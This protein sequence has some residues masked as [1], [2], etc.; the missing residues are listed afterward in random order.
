MNAAQERPD[1]DAVLRGLK[2]FQRETVERIFERMYGPQPSRRFLLADEVGLGKTL[3]AKGLIAKTLDHLWD[4]V[5]RIDVIYICSNADIARQN[6][7][8]LHPEEGGFTLPSRIT[9]LPLSIGDLASRKM[10]FVSFTPGTSLEPRSAMGTAEERALLVRMLR[11]P[12]EMGNRR[13]PCKVFQATSRSIESFE[14]SVREVDDRPLSEE[15]TA[16][17]REAVAARA[18]LQEA[19]GELLER[20][21]RVREPSSLPDDVKAARRGLI[22]ELRHLLAQTCVAALE[23]DLILLDEFQRFRHLLSGES[24][25]ADLA[26]ELFDWEDEDTGAQA[27]VLLMSATPYKMF[28]VHGEAE[29]D[30]YED[31]V[32]TLRFL[33]GEERATRLGGLLT[34]FRRE[35][36]SFDP[37]DAEGL[38]D[39]HE[40]IQRE[41]RQ[42][43]VRTERLGAGN[44]ANGMLETV[45]EPA[46]PVTEADVAD[47]LKGQQVAR[48]VG[49]SDVM[50]YWKSAPYLLNMLGD[51]YKVIR[52][53][54]ASVDTASGRASMAEILPSARLLGSDRIRRWGEIDA[55]SPR[56]RGLV[57]SMVGGG[58]WR[59]LWMPPS[60]PY[61]QLGG[62]FAG[63]PDD[64]TKRLVFSS[65]TVVPRAIASIV[66]YA[67]ERE[68]WAAGGDRSLNTEQ[69]RKA[70]Q[71]R[72]G[73]T[74]DERGRPTGMPLL[75][76]LFPTTTLAELCDPLVGAGEHDEPLSIDELRRWARDRVLGS[77]AEVTAGAA[78]DGPEDQAWYWLAPLLL[79]ARGSDPEAREWLERADAVGAWSGGFRDPDGSAGWAE[80]VDL[81]RRAASGELDD[82]GRPPVDLADV[83]AEIGL[84]G[85]GNSARRSLTRLAAPGVDGGALRVASARIAWGLRSLFNLPEV[86]A[87][88]PGL[89]GEGAYWRQCLEYSA[90]GGL[91]AVLDEYLHLLVEALG[92]SEGSTEVIEK[93]SGRVSEVLT[94]RAGQ[95]VTDE[96]VIDPS[97]EAIEFRPLRFRSRFAARFGDQEDDEGSEKTH[98]D[99]L[100][101]S[102]N[103]PFWPFVLASTSVGQEGLD[104]HH[105]CHSVV[106]WNLPPNPV[107]LEQREGR[108]HRF[109][110]HAVRKNLARHYGL[111]GVSA[112][113]R[114][115]DPWAGLFEAGRRDRGS[116]ENDLVPYWL[117]PI[118]GGAVIERRV[119]MLPLSEEIERFEALRRSLTAYRL[120]FGQPRQEDLVAYLLERFSEEQVA[121]LSE[122]YRIDLSPR[123]RRRRAVSSSPGTTTP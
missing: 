62:P 56:M 113:G 19:Y 14:W 46:A 108:V 13:G 82:L 16:A 9:L 83:V 77:L 103:S 41:L 26:R 111:G 107:D 84:F 96:V 17:F 7:N 18:D 48:A 99:S 76:I 36:L 12:W 24:E 43:I 110:N 4:E 112:G 65:W 27:R 71:G 49:G 31:F 67:A 23:P 59:L 11:E 25:T 60:L 101:A 102:F 35:L 6:L 3:V 117:F 20:Y 85:W 58:H 53:V 52:Q 73:F 22:G 15:L 123:C 109:K 30:H 1:V 51:G 69:V 75:A 90:M 98:A 88:V 63:L 21:A 95:V 29:D 80:H 120:A 116:E 114:G 66:S 57:D 68:L 79:D 47:Y 89:V 32:A 91:Q 100:R 93:V 28:T 38:G 78:T 45:L 106:H 40:Q 105:Y 97:A 64:L 50:E 119:P 2:D 122:R 42:V 87:L 81:A 37:S 118:D 121:E 61:Y 10:N 74:T 54:K 72:L 5:E 104:F 44:D 92:F 34:R 33:A 86:H 94:L 70:G 8:R 115:R 39:L 55:G